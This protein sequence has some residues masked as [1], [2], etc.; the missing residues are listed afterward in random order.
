MASPSNIYKLICINST[1]F[2]ILKIY[3]LYPLFSSTKANKHKIT[4]RS[5]LFTS[6]TLMNTRPELHMSHFLKTNPT[7]KYWT[8]PN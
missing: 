2:T 4:K 3:V 1:L 7:Q 6:W 8:Q 5:S